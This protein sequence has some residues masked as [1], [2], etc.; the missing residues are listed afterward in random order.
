M[1]GGSKEEILIDAAND[2]TATI[3]K[4]SSSDAV[5]LV[6]TKLTDAINKIGTT[7]KNKRVSSTATTSPQPPVTDTLLQNRLTPEDSALLDDAIF[8]NRAAPT[9]FLP[10]RK[11]KKTAKDRYRPPSPDELKSNFARAHISK[12]GQHFIDTET[13]EEFIIDS[14]FFSNIWPWI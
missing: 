12:I 13:S 1:P 5:K 6:A 2:L 4:N 3:A 11:R 8:S 7:R 14:I 9:D 10:Q